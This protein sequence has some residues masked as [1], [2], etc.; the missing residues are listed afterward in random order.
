MHTCECNCAAPLNSI[1]ACTHN[2][3]PA[4]SHHFMDQVLPLLFSMDV[5]V[6]RLTYV[7]KEER[8]RIELCSCTYGILWDNLTYAIWDS[9]IGWIALCCSTYG[10]P[11]CPMRNGRIELYCGIHRPIQHVLAGQCT[12]H[13]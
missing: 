6:D 2:S 1:T 13:S 4:E 5:K 3:I 9:K 11:T 10:G 12:G 7:H 8:H